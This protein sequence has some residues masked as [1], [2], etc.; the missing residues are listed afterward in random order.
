MAL[1]YYCPHGGKGCVVR[2]GGAFI[3]SRIVS[4]PAE[5]SVDKSGKKGREGG[6][7]LDS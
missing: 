3:T 5:A 7:Q 2:E 4:W 1:G 6:V